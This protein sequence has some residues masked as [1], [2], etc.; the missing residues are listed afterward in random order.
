[1]PH[2]LI[3]SDME[4]RRPPKLWTIEECHRLMERGELD[5]R[6]ELIEGI[7]YEPMPKHAPHI[8][9]LILIVKWLIRIYDYDFVQ[10]EDPISIPGKAGKFNEPEPDAAVL[11]QPTVS[12]LHRRPGPED[13]L[14]VVEVSDSTLWFDKNI[15]AKVY[16]RAGIVEYWVMDVKGRQIYRHRKPGRNGYGEIIAFGEDEMIAAPGREETA[17]VGELFAPVSV[18]NE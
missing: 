10:R 3:A 14:F 16:A 8:V 7:I 1:M 18:T 12:F 11:T 17:R 13:I 2:T 5:E 9:A 15:K 6:Y 4:T